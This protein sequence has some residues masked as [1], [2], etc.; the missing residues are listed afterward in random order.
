MKDRRELY[1]DSHRKSEHKTSKRERK[2]EGE[3]IHRFKKTILSQGWREKG[4]ED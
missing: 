4:D 3:G 1:R 2:R